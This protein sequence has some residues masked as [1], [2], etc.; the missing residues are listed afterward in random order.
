MAERLPQIKGRGFCCL[1]SIHLCVSVVSL[2]TAGRAE[3]LLSAKAHN[4]TIKN[5]DAWRIKYVLRAVTLAGDV[6]SYWLCN[7]KTLLIAVISG[8]LGGMSQVLIRYLCS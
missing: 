8:A 5:T 1:P 4:C 2:S 3:I 6:Y 7:R